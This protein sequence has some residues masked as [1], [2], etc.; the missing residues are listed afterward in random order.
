[1]FGPG[2][3]CK[4]LLHNNEFYLNQHSETCT[5]LMGVS[6]LLFVLSTFIVDLDEI[7]SKI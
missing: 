5:L 6:K 7:W 2:D 4:F 3:V 1:M